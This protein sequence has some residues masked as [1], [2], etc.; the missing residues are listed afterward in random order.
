MRWWKEAVLLADSSNPDVVPPNRVS[1]NKWNLK[2]D[3]V[4]PE[5]TGEYVCKAS[6]VTTWGDVTQ[7]YAIQ[8]L[9]MENQ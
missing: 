6:R 1:M 8:V 3:D 2:I 5:D 7:V 4:R 9:C